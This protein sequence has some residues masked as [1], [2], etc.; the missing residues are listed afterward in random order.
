[1]HSLTQACNFEMKT[2]IKLDQHGRGHFPLSWKCFLVNSNPW[3]W[4]STQP[5]RNMLCSKGIDHTS[6][7]KRDNEY[8]SNKIMDEYH[9][10]KNNGTKY[11]VKII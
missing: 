5:S 1:V 4:M 9:L 2:F 8:R 10:T 3:F 11:Y 6:I 7:Y